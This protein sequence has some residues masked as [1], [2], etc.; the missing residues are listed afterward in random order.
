MSEL[1]NMNIAILVDNYFEQVEMTEPKDVMESHGASVHLIS[2]E[3]KMVQGMNHAELADTFEADNLIDEVEPADYDV[4]I[5][6]GGTINGD[7]L[8]GKETAQEWVQYFMNSNKPLAII[9]HGPWILISA[10]CIEGKTLT[11]YPS[12]ELDLVNAGATEW[13]DEPVVVDEN[14]ITSRTPDDL[15]AFTSAI[16]EQVKAINTY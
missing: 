10:D 11:S 5:I 3:Q 14:L 2:T 13:L 8:R 7:Q 4:L 16:L 1:E 6:P 12:L 15:H 9:C